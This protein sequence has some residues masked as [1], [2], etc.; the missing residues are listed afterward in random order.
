MDAKV[1]QS[2]VDVLNRELIAAMGCTEPIA[3]A[4][5][6]AKA[7]EVLGEL[8][9]RAVVHCS[10]NII[11]NVKSVTVPNSGG[12]AGIEIA[13][14]LGIVGGD[15]SAQLEVL[16]G[17]T[18]EDRQKAKEL[19]DRGF[20]VCKLQENVDNLYVDV[21]VETEEH[22]AQV[23]VMN[24]HTLIARIAKDGKEIHRQDVINRIQGVSNDFL[25][26]AGI[27]EF[28]STAD[29]EDI[30]GPIERQIRLNTA[31]SK[32]GMS[33]KYGAQI[34]NVLM[35][36]FGTDVR[37]RAMAVAAAGSDARMS[38]CAMP[39]VINS[40]SGNQGMTV[41]LP[42]LEYAKELGCSHEKTCRA[43]VVSNLI[44]IHIKKYIGD[45][46]AFCGAV[47]AACGAGAAITYLYGGTLQQ[48]SN[49]VINTVANVGGILCDG[50]KASCAAKIA[51]SVN[52]AIL[53][54][55]M[56][57]AGIVFHEDEGIVLDD[58]ESTIRSIGHIGCVGMARTDT[59]I[60]KI[61]MKEVSF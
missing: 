22:S 44:S 47:S 8:P 53:G 37:V 5:A 46:S 17:V 34:G 59:E 30:R 39:V 9:D 56:S 40:G 7:R 54:H 42:V 6:A 61:M 49:T 19:L 41:S 33:E 24:R 38:G 28:A 45:L 25:S 27:Y 26:M 3:I 21:Y 16:A 11:K 12:M 52:A 20:C 51:S 23:T 13:A 10:G 18:D 14:I 36:S 31:I 48:I 15:A 58:V 55:T 35:K 32:E 60:L 50:A 57:M 1:Y 4:Y 29:F 43:L 2:Y